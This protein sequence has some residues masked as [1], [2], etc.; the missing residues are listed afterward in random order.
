MMKK[1]TILISYPESSWAVN[2]I[3]QVGQLTQGQFYST[4]ARILKLQ[5]NTVKKKN[6]VRVLFYRRT[7]LY[8]VEL[9]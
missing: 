3:K 2:S 7:Q 8:K 4:T 6:N 5:H 9:D 1:H